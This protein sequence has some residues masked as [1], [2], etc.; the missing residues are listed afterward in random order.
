MASKDRIAAE[1]ESIVK[2]DILGAADWRRSKIGWFTGAAVMRRS[3]SSLAGI[4]VGAA[5]NVKAMAGAV[6]RKETAIALPTESADQAERFRVAQAVHRRSDREIDLDV[7][8]T[9]KIFNLYF[10]LSTIL[11]ALGIATWNHGTG[12]IPAWAEMVSRFALLPAL[13]ALAVRASFFNWQLRTR[14]LGTL[15]EWA[16]SPSEWMASGAGGDKTML[17]SL[18][19]LLAV[20]A[21]AAAMVPMSVAAQGVGTGAGGMSSIFSPSGPDDIWTMMLSYVFPG[22]GPL[23]ASS[24]GTEMSRQQAAGI[25]AASGSFL[26]VLMALSSVMLSWHILSGV[27]ATAHEG[28]VLGQRWHQVWAPIRVVTGFGFLAPVSN[29]YCMAQVLVIQIALWGGAFGNT[30][31]GSYVDT[32]GRVT[33]TEVPSASIVPTV[34]DVMALEVCRA[35]MMIQGGILEAARAGAGGAT[36]T[37]R[38]GGGIQT[39]LAGSVAANAD[40]GTNAAVAA[41]NLEGARRAALLADAWAWTPNALQSPVSVVSAAVRSVFT[42]SLAPWTLSTGT[43]DYGACGRMQVVMQRSAAAAATGGGNTALLTAREQF[44]SARLSALDALLGVA[45]ESATNIVLSRTAGAPQPDGPIDLSDV[46]QAIRT[47][48]ESLRSASTALLSAINGLSMDALKAEMKKGGWATSGTYY[49]TI[50]R[51]FEAYHTLMS[52]RPTLTIGSETDTGRRLLNEIAQP[53]AANG[54]GTLLALSDAW[55]NMI[56]TQPDISLRAVQAGTLSGDSTDPHEVL[57][58]A[59]QGPALRWSLSLLDIDL[60]KGSALSHMIHFGHFIL[61]VFGWGLVALVLAVAGGSII[62]GMVGFVSGTVASGGNPVAGGGAG[63]AAAM[64]SKVLQALM[65]FATLALVTLFVIGIIHAYVLPMIPYIQMF[66]FILGMLTLVVEGVIAAPLWAF[67]HIRMDGQEFVDQVQRPGYMIVFNLLLRIPLALFGMFFSFLVFDIM[68]W[69]ESVTFRAT[70]MGATATNGYGLFGI[71]V[72]MVMFS[73]LHYQVAMRSFS[74]IVQVPDRVSRWFGQ[75]SEGMHEDDNTKQAAGLLVSK[76]ETK[77][78]RLGQ[79][80]GG[81]MRRPGKPGEE[82][83]K[84]GKGGAAATGGDTASKLSPP[85]D[86]TK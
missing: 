4:F 76:V 68:L 63:L 10:V 57:D 15:R 78:E 24:M 37:R 73:Y 30:I 82:P 39:R 17:S 45:R 67:F 6:F 44:D 55:R 86:G 27:V 38:V 26:S 77:T 52:E 33:V 18:A 22:V 65:T 71:L 46:A 11:V 8:A 62:S 79:G 51:M 66:F 20:G 36:P 58:S 19:A 70:F 53:L 21:A 25:A 1:A 83:G 81:S 54:S 13:V 75:G 35:T 3:F 61:T 7:V 50:S 47:Y 41:A 56:Q 84:D 43:R 14:R 40:A 49:M 72:A 48:E 85:A 69:F 64:G 9:N 29:G 34:R 60:N 59:L 42:F 74:L 16:R 12:I 5:S 32:L 2:D 23:S 31:W 80:M 28:K